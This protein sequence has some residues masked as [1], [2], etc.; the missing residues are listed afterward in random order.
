[1]NSGSLSQAIKDKCTPKKILGS[2][3]LL[4]PFILVF[5]I[6]SLKK[7]VLEAVVLFA[8]SLFLFLMIVVGCKLVFDR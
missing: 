8:V 7:S 2:V 5:I 3:L 4:L 6:A 1:M